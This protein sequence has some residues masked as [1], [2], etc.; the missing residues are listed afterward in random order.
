MF[1]IIP[2]ALSMREKANVAKANHAAEVIETNKEWLNAAVQYIN[3]CAASGQTVANV[4]WP[5]GLTSCADKKILSKKFLE[6]GYYVDETR[7][8]IA[9][10]CCIA[11]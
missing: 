6:A 7:D 9:N 8:I 1:N 11:W 10:Y 5:D 3:E 2:S 4:P